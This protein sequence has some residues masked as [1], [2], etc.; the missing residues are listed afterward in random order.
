[1]KNVCEIV[2][3]AVFLAFAKTSSAQSPSKTQG[4]VIPN[5]GATYEIPNPD[6]E[7]DTTLVFKAVFDLVKA[8]KDPSK[9]N[10]HIETVARFINMHAN[11]GV[12]VENLKV[13]IAMH[14][15]AS[16]GLLKNDYY[17]DKFGVDNPNS[18]LL[19]AIDNTGVEIILC[20]QTAR[21]RNLSQERRLELADIA[22]SAMTILTQSQEE[23]Y[24]L[25][26]F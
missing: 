4:I 2:C 8:P 23:G 5:F 1:M 17:K 22:L 19:E 20:G 18:E 26:A 3:P 14:C 11:A 13:R 10:P 25:I 7:T 9:R 6:F 21:S 12:P 16:Y 24:H 15:K